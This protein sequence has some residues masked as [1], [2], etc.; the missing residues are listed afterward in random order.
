METSLRLDNIR[1]Q[2]IPVLAL[3]QATKS[4]LGAWDIF[5]WVFKILKL[6]I[7][8]RDLSTIVKPS[9]E[10]IFTP[11]NPFGLVGVGV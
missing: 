7:H 6:E 3:L 2:V 10:S 8:Q 5:L 1:D 9:Y 4:H 11:G